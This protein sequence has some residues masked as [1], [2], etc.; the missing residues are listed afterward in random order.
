ME[1]SLSM[2]C[3]TRLACTCSA[4]LAALKEVQALAKEAFAPGAALPRL[5]A[6]GLAASAALRLLHLAAVDAR[7]MPMPVLVSAVYSWAHLGLRNGRK[8]KRRSEHVA[9]LAHEFANGIAPQ[10]IKESMRLELTAV[11]TAVSLRLALGGSLQEVAMLKLVPSDAPGKL[12]RRALVAP[13]APRGATQATALMWAT[14]QGV[15]WVQSM[16]RL[17]ADPNQ[18]TPCGWSALIYGAAFESRNMSLDGVSDS[19]EDYGGYR[20]RNRGVVGP[21]LDARAD[22]S[23]QSLASQEFLSAFGPSPVDTLLVS[24]ELLAAFEGVEGGW[25]QELL[26]S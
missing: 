5:V 12:D 21:L 14:R 7:A 24:A 10:G 6:K 13:P 3:W 23:V 26:S 9:L 1:P 19:T 17:G 15:R 18:L 25:A 4:D 22:P 20:S 16:L 8:P 11:E 2:C